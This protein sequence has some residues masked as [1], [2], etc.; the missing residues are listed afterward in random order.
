MIKIIDN[1]LTKSYHKNILE[2]LTY[3][4]FEWVYLPNITG[5]ADCPEF[6]EFNAYGL[7]HIFWHEEFGQKHTY[8]SHFITPLLYQ[9][10][11]VAE[12]NYIL[13]ARADMVTWT[14]KE[15]F[16]HP[17]HIDFSYPNIASVFYVNDSDGD[18]IF[19]NIKPE[20]V[21]IN[22]KTYEVMKHEELTEYD[23]VSPKANRVVLFEGDHFHTGCSP[24]KHKNRILI[25]SNYSKEDHRKK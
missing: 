10:M 13:R 24:T 15:E 17:A 18:T 19:Y 3:Q 21:P 20:D 14:G 23:R 22:G 7:S 25:N 8:L 2:F 4:D 6:P 12:C 1:F 16:I 9:I 11:D 5:I